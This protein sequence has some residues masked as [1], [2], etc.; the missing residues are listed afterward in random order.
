MIQIRSIF[1]GKEQNMRLKDKKFIPYYITAA[2]IILL[3]VL[4]VIIIGHRSGEETPEE[5]PTTQEPS[6]LFMNGEVPYYA[7]VAASAY[8]KDSFS[9]NE[10]GRMVYA[11]DA[12]SYTTGIDVSSHQ[13]EIDW[14]AVKA[15]GIDFAMIRIGFRGYGASGNLCEDDRGRENIENA[16]DAGLSVGVYF[17]SQATTPEEAA[18]EADFVLEILKDHDIEYPVVFDWENEPDVAM[19]TDG[20]TGDEITDCAVAFCE[21]IKNAGYIPAVYFNLTDAYVRYDLSRIKDYPF[22]Y[23]QHEGESPLFYYQYTI[24]QYSDTGSVD[25]ID[26]NVD[27]NIAFSDFSEYAAVG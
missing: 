25:G 12:V 26:G 18:E 19:R 14:D 22:W 20:M 3:A 11:D 21:K 23:A 16:A 5:V 4:I 6:T 24:W 8:K 9:L 17:Y 10:D 7:D 13:G 1:D 15:D 27:L 2:V